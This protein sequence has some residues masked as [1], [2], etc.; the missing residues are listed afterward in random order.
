M[1]EIILNLCKIKKINRAEAQTTQFF[2][3][4]F[5]TNLCLN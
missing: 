2:I 4:T 5:K 1:L 3:Y